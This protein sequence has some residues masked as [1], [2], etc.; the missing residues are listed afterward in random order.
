MRFN[1]P[2][3]LKSRQG[4]IRLRKKFIWRPRHFRGPNTFWLCSKTVV[5]MITRSDIGE[6]GEF[7]RYAWGWNEVGF[8]DT[9][10][11]EDLREALYASTE[12]PTPSFEMREQW[13]TAMGWETEK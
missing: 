1:N 5:E 9:V 7:G 2:L 6:T 8:A 4:E 3:T 11:V 13:F 10:Q 12:T